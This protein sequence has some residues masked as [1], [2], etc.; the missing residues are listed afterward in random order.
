MSPKCYIWI[1]FVCRY[2]QSLKSQDRI[3]HPAYIIDSLQLR[4]ISASK[5][6]HNENHLL[7]VLSL[8]NDRESI[9]SKK[10]IL[11]NLFA[12]S[13]LTASLNI[14]CIN[15]I[16]LQVSSETFCPSDASSLSG[17]CGS[18][19][20][21]D[22]GFPRN[23][24][25]VAMVSSIH[26][27]KL[28]YVSYGEDKALNDLTVTLLR[29]RSVFKSNSDYS[30][31]KCIQ[32]LTESSDMGVTGSVESIDFQLQRLDCENLAEDSSFVTA[33]PNIKSRVPFVVYRGDD[34]DVDDIS[35]LE[36]RLSIP[37]G[38]IMLEF[39]MKSITINGFF[40]TTL[41]SLASPDLKTSSVKGKQEYGRKI[42]REGPGKQ[43]NVL[44]I[45]SK[46]GLQE[47]EEIDLGTSNGNETVM[48]S[49]ETDVD[50]VEPSIL[51][52]YGVNESHSLLED[53]EDN[54]I[55]HVVLE[56]QE[57]DCK[58]DDMATSAKVE[59]EKSP[60]GIF[61]ATDGNEEEENK[62][63]ILKSR[64]EGEM[65]VQ[66]IWFNL[67]HPTELKILQDRNDYSVNLISSIVP[68]ICSWIPVHVDL[69]KATDIL[70]HN[71]YRHR[72]SVMA[73]IMGQ[74]LPDKGRLYIKV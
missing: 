6:K 1:V 64:S 60:E 71:Y 42:T 16:A 32:D 21:N 37:V 8:P 10:S 17:Q 23:T 20:S 29:R 57:S 5:D 28:S 4:C 66:K 74:A 41:S 25:A 67:A 31:L 18:K 51:V 45:E 27:L 61:S 70:L 65:N 11:S 46:D 56:I 12:R 38:K 47:I 13:S 7:K 19:F 44:D 39:G 33:V 62:E 40:G 49:R 50:V 9:A 48:P 15:L 54:I 43:R 52:D 30:L 35:W 69:I 36:Q 63:F 24:C 72:Y 58:A 55:K 26:N 59:K 14:P 2:I 68:S 34:V 53:E 22:C 3:Q 73:Y